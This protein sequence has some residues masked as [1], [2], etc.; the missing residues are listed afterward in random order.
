MTEKQRQL[1]LFDENSEN[2]DTFFTRK[3]P[4]SA[5]KHRILLRYIQAYCYNLGGNRP[6]QSRYANYVDGFAG[7]GKYDEGV[8]IEDFI[9]RSHFWQRYEND[10]RDT[11][12]SPLI[13][14]KCAK[15]FRLVRL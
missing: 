11:D 14:L 5:A 9:D 3:R 1:S 6:F 10:F 15:I 2:S 12:G 13:A 4:W 7:E 8:G